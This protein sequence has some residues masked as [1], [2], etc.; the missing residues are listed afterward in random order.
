MADGRGHLP[1]SEFPA[2]GETNAEAP[3]RPFRIRY[4][5]VPSPFARTSTCSVPSS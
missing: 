1:Q 5:G 3:D 4:L 2:Q